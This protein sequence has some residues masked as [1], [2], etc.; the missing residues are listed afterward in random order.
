VPSQSSSTPLHVASPLA[1]VV[2]V[3]LFCTLPFTHDVV[4]VAAQPPTPQLVDWGVKPSSTIPSQSSSI[5][6][7]SVSGPVEVH[8]SSAA[9]IPP[10]TPASI[11]PSTPPS[12][13]APQP[14]C[15]RKHG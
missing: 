14:A 8:A 13:N 9:S 7:Q 1:G 11:P 4:P 5:P 10:S 15:Q 3:Q 6:S 12:G 2:G